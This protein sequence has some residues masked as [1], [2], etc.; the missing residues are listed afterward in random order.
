MDGWTDGQCPLSC[1]PMERVRYTCRQ[2]G[3][4]RT[5]LALEREFKSSPATE[6]RVP[7]PTVFTALNW[8]HFPAPNVTRLPQ[9]REQSPREAAP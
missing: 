7:S 3:F 4:G 5:G 9:E 1:R 2:T 8:K 6:E